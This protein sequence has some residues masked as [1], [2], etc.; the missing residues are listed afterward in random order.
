M[1]L[2][3]LTLMTTF[4][5]LPDRDAQGVAAADVFLAPVVIAASGRDRVARAQ[6]IVA[7]AD[8]RLRGDRIVIAEPIPRRVSVAACRRDPIVAA[9][10]FLAVF[11]SPPCCITV[12]PSP[13]IF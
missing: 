9:R 6:E 2:P 4:R 11:S 13:R 8:Y 3:P 1:L 10:R 7:R 5:L 12:L